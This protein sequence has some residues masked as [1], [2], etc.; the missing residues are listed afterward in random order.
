MNQSP[1]QM[2]AE[3]KI[4]PALYPLDAFR[5]LYPDAIIP[6]AF[7]IFT[8]EPYPAT[9]PRAAFRLAGYVPPAGKQAIP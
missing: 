2:L 4:A 8:R 3:G 9:G 5:I 1:A 6:G 7:W